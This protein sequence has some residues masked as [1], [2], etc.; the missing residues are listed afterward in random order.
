MPQY[1][2]VALTVPLR[3]TFTYAVPEALLGVVEPGCRVAV[4]FRNRVMVGVVLEITDSPPAFAKEESSRGK[5]KIREIAHVLDPLPALNAK[6]IELGRWVG[7]YY[8]APPGD[9]FRAMLPPL[10]ELRAER[11]LRMTSAGRERLSELS[12]IQ[13]RSEMEVTEH[14]LLELIEV[15]GEPLAMQRLRKLPGGEAAAARLLRRGQLEAEEIARARKTRM[16]KIIAWNPAAPSGPI[17]VIDKDVP[18]KKS[19]TTSARFA[20]AEERVR[21]VLAEECGPLPLKLLL[22]RAEV[23][24]A[25]VDRLMNQNKLKGWEEAGHHRRRFFRRGLHCALQCAQ[26]GT[27]TSCRRA[28][29]VARE[30]R[31][32]GGPAPRRYGQ[33]QDGSVSARRA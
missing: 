21:R 11:I 31:I 30:G 1:C 25:V 28:S 12:A 10:T 5:I 22:E 26:R 14:A 18:A 32:C 33:W 3:T 23:S 9:V 19:V 29:R 6:L 15:E 4:P 27:G 13:N 2:E 24:Q 16:Q 7:S 8:L 20:A 17:E